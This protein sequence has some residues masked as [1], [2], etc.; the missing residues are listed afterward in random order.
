MAACRA[1][2]RRD[3]EEEGAPVP[4]GGDVV[5]RVPMESGGGRSGAMPRGVGTRAASRQGAS[6][7]GRPT[8]S[9]EDNANERRPG[10]R[11]TFE[12][13][14]TEALLHSRRRRPNRAVTHVWLV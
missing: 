3:S 6:V 11:A 9:F 10:R 12:R 1:K 13:G 4:E 2:A 8:R 14:V 7:R 5:R